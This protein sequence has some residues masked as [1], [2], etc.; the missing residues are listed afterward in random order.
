MLQV[1]CRSV[2]DLCD[3]E[4][5]FKGGWMTKDVRYAMFMLLFHSIFAYVRS[6]TIIDAKYVEGI[7]ELHIECQ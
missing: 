3:G 1:S 7:K 2:D 6:W 5:T 4:C